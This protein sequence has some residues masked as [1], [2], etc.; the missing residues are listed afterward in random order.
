VPIS[1]VCEPNALRT[2]YLNPFAALKDTAD[3]D[4]DSHAPRAD[5]G[6]IDRHSSS[7]VATTAYVQ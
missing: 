2:P 4:I 7:C 1:R 6:H 5:A 3:D